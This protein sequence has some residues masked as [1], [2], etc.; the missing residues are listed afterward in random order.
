MAIQVNVPCTVTVKVDTG[1]ANALE[2]WCE[3][4]EGIS[5][6]EQTFKEPIHSDTNGGTA[7]PPVDLLVHGEVHVITFQSVR[8]DPVV[9]AKVRFVRSI[10][11]GTSTGGCVLAFADGAFYRVLLTGANFV[12]NYVRVMVED[13]ELGKIGSHA[14]VRQITLTCYKNDSGVLWNSTAT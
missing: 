12:R 11:D 2:S 1:S 8:F 9:D 6:R 13:K 7:G 10:A 3:S 4:I 14:S 5:I